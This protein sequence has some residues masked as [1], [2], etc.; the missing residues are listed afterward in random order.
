MSCPKCLISFV[1]AFLL[2][3]VIAFA[4]WGGES[5]RLDM[6]DWEDVASNREGQAFYISRKDVIQYDKARDM[7]RVV[8]LTVDRN[9]KQF[10]YTVKKNE[11]H[12]RANVFHIMWEETYRSNYTRHAVIHHNR[13]RY[14]PYIEGSLLDQ[15]CIGIKEKAHR[16]T[17]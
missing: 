5:R 17:G 6:R 8:V 3:V 16:I 1:V 12:C 2:T 7:L 4:A 15:I 10:P 13:Y 9:D 14:I 11:V